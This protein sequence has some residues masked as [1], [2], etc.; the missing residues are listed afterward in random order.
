[1]AEVAVFA[2]EKN[3]FATAAAAVAAA[4][5]EAIAARGSFTFAVS[6][7]SSAKGLFPV[8]AGRGNELIDW[9]RTK[10]W[11]VDE[12]AVPPED[13][14]SNYKLACDLLLNRVAIPKDHVYRMHADDPDLDWAA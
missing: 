13:P 3:L 1:M 11:W 10:L 2:D 8:L 7:G 5:S 4:A 14:D 6:G 9:V 12:R